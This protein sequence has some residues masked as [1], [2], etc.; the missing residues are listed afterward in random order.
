VAASHDEF[1]VAV[2]RAATAPNEG[3]I[4]RGLEQA[5]HH[6]WSSI[7]SRMERIIQDAVQAREAPRAAGARRLVDRGGAASVPAHRSRTRAP[8]LNLTAE[9]PDT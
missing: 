8:A 2:Q 9:A 4:K 1:V 3:L 5:S 7:V 6:S